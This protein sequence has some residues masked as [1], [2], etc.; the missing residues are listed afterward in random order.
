MVFNR[1]KESEVLNPAKRALQPALQIL[2]SAQNKIIIFRNSIMPSPTFYDKYANRSQ[3][4]I[5]HCLT[6]E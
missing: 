1:I 3:A 4:I 6:I 5:S 2:S